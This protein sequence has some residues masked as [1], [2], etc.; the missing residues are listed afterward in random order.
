MASRRSKRLGAKSSLKAEPGSDDQ[1]DLP[2]EKTI[3]RRASVYDAVAGAFPSLSLISSS[4]L[5]PDL[6]QGS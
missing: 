3:R 5:V 4:S 1:L 6:S 2:G